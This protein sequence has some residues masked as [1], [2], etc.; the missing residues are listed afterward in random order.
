MTVPLVDL[1]PDLDECAR[2]DRTD[3]DKFTTDDSNK[4]V[5]C[6]RKF[7]KLEVDGCLC[8]GGNGRG[9]V[10][11]YEIGLMHLIRAV[12]KILRI[13]VRGGVGGSNLCRRSKVLISRNGC[14]QG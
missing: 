14:R 2:S 8:G 6:L 11:L 13:A 10:L 5:F 1:L 12:G 3:A 7:I 4:V 9:S